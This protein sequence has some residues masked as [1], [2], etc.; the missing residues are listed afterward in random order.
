MRIG[1]VVVPNEGETIRCLRSA[2]DGGRF[3]NEVVLAGKH[4][5]PPLH[6]H[7]DSEE[8][9]IIE[10]ELRLIFADGERRLRAG[11][12]YTIPAGT[13]HTFANA[14]SGRLVARGSNGAFFER[15]VEQ[16]G[17]ERPGFAKLAVFLCTP[18]GRAS[19]RVQAP[20]RAV[21]EVVA[22][23]GRLRGIRPE[24]AAEVGQ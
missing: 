24:P 1:D 16:F 11:D 12:K 15:I 23:I 19:Y 8:I 20:V 7:S 6:A 10:G 3:E 21:L 2:R 14:T 4:D 5:A 18:E 9:E 22:F 17:G 13:L